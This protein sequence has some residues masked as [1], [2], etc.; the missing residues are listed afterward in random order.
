MKKSE[1]IVLKSDQLYINE[2]EQFVEQICDEH[3]IYNSYYANILTSVIEAYTNAVEHGNKF[4]PNKFVRI[5][6][7]QEQ[8]GLSFQIQDQG[9]GFDINKIPDPTDLSNEGI[10]GRGIFMIKALSDQVDF[11][12]NGR[13]IKLSFRISSINREVA[14]KRADLFHHFI[15]QSVKKEQNI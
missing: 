10:E 13:S 12:D 3:N 6:F 14:T 1:N 8:Q 4:D 5:T 11:E 15:N 9:D 7:N 2:V